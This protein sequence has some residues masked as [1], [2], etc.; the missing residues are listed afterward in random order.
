MTLLKRCSRRERERNESAFLSVL[1]EETDGTCFVSDGGGKDK[2]IQTGNKYVGK[3][4]RCLSAT[5]E[6]IN[7]DNRIMSQQIFQMN[8]K[9][10]DSF[11]PRV[12]QLDALA[13]DSEIFTI[14]KGSIKSALKHFL[15]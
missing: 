1:I 10:G 12:N 6:E 14:F 9:D 4:Q 15:R 2:F 5:K 13:L 3:F 8:D 7:D 11:V